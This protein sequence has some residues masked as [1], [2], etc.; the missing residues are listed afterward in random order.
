MLLQVMRKQLSFSSK[1][2]RDQRPLYIYGN[3]MLNP[4]DIF[5]K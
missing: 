3:G 5:L 2:R 4:S 1:T